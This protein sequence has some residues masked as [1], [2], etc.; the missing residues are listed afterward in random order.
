MPPSIRDIAQHTG[1][2]SAAV[3][4]ALRGVGRIPE[5]T[6]QRVITAAKTLGYEPQ[7]LLAKAL[8]LA[9]K[10]KTER[11]RENLAFITEFS[12]DDPSLDPFPTYQ[13]EL[14]TGANERAL[15]L[16]FKLE[17]FTLS[18]NPLEHRR[19]SRVLQARG[20]RG[21]IVIPRL[22]SDQPRLSLNWANFA[23]VEIGRTLWYPRNLH[24]VETADYNK[25]IEALHLLKK[26]GYRRIGMAVEPAQNKH[27]RGTYYA[28]YLLQQMKQAPRQRIPIASSTGEWCEKTFR[29][30]MTQYQPDVLIAHKTD[31]ISSWL[32]KMGMK[33]PRDVSMFCVD[34][35]D[36][37]LSG[38]RRDYHGLGRHAVEMVS[39]LLDSG[40]LGLKGNPRCLQVDEFW[41]A[42]KTLSRS[43]TPHISEE[44]FLLTKLPS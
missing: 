35:Q 25:V 16:G 40:E 38:L 20:I 15:S 4:L 44:G 36:G 10:S 3:S 31:T 28:A 17:S 32:K 37:D 29:A 41:Q 23:S 18:G 33:I 6:R 34:A 1:L 5:A 2:S 24:H 8:S 30:W 9:R 42:G 26:A 43:I 27:Q 11:Y 19:M 7:P 39:M 12:L 13:K 22:I 14:F 21:L